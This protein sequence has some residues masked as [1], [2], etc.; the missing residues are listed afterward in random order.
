[1]NKGT[2][3]PTPQAGYITIYADSGTGILRYK[4]SDGT[5]HDLVGQNDPE[6]KAITVELPGVS[7]NIS[8]F[9]T[10][11]AI[12]IYKV[13]AVLKGT[14]P[15][16]TWSL[17]HGTDRSA[18]GAELITGGTV[19]TN[20]TT[21]QEITSFDDPTIVANSHLWLTF[22]AK[23]GVVDSFSLTIYYNED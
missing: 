22:S 7:D 18:A 16:L 12:T 3:P 2:E 23:S 14:T 6:L 11:V 21:G 15:S 5:V 19:I 1:M 9:D 8:F 20:T 13:R 17:R 10:D 4:K